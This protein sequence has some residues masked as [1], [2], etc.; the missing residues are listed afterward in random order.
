M[1]AITEANIQMEEPFEVTLCIEYTQA[2][3]NAWYNAAREYL[4][5]AEERKQR[6]ETIYVS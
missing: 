3:E 2:W 4:V 6:E 1:S 5:K